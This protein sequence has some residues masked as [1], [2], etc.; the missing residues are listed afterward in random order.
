M[1]MKSIEVAIVSTKLLYQLANSG[2]YVKLLI[3]SIT[4]NRGFLKILTKS[5]K[6]NAK[7]SL[8]YLN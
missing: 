2:I 8:I 5:F 7:L 3:S 6:Q 1:G 4:I